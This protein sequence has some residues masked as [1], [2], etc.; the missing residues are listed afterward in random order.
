M[1]FG[2]T[3]DGIVRL[4][5]ATYQLVGFGDANEFL[6]T[7]HLL[8]RPCLNF[9]FIAGNTDCRAL[10][11]GHGV[12]PVSIAS[13]FSQ[14]ARTCSSVA[15]ARMTTNMT[16]PQHCSLSP[17]RPLGNGNSGLGEAARWPIYS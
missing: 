7:R 13:I 15:C 10:R 16:A 1:S 9:A 5:I 6:D 17:G 12:S 8:E 14:T 3:N 2:E 11:T 4:H